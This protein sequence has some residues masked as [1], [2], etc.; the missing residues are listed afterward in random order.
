LAPR[1]EAGPIATKRTIGLGGE[2]L[3]VVLD[4]NSTGNHIETCLSSMQ[5]L[6]NGVLHHVL[7]AVRLTSITFRNPNQDGG[8]S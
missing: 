1:N 2:I 3:E 4:C 5:S 8:S 7:Y 6:T